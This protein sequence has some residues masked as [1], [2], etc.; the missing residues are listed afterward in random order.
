[1][2]A[3]LYMCGDGRGRD[4]HMSLFFVLMKGPNDALLRFP[5]E[6]SVMFCLFDQSGS[7]RDIVYSIAPD[8]SNSFQRPTSDMN[9]S[10]GMPKFAP[11][12]ALQTEGKYVVND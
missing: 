8:N 9:I 11:I 1:M 5:S 6:Y 4:T 3:K 7:G 10:N 12:S 2:C